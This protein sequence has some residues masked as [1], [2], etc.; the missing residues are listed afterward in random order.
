MNFT[1]IQGLVLAIY[2]ILVGLSTLVA[3]AI[4]GILLRIVA[5]IA[6]ISILGSWLRFKVRQLSLSAS[7]R[8]C[9]NC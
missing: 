8:R 4:L 7:W 3:F 1:K 5:L 6:G 9:S 2:L